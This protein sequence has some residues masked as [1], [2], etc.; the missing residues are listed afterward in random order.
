MGLGG[1]TVGDGAQVGHG[2]VVVFG[3]EVEGASEDLDF[4]HEGLFSLV[5]LFGEGVCFFVF[6]EEGVQLEGL[7]GED[8]FFLLAGA[9]ALF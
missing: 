2:D 5:E 8:D 7:L 3:F 9:G 6:D 1:V 4:F